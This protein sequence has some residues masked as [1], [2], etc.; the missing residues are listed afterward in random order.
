M[1]IR[2]GQKAKILCTV[3]CAVASISGVEVDKPQ[4]VIK[5]ATGQ[6]S[7]QGMPRISLRRPKAKTIP[8]GKESKITAEAM[9]KVSINPPQRLT[10]IGVKIPKPPRIREAI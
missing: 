7:H 6:M 3:F 5:I 2:R 10:L 8:K 4:R 1:R 9:I